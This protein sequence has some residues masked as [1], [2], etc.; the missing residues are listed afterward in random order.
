MKQI[1]VFDTWSEHAELN[2]SEDSYTVLWYDKIHGVEPFE[3]SY[4]SLRQAV[5]RY[6][7]FMNTN[8]ERLN[9]DGSRVC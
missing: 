2:E 7:E 3:K 1:A 4:T 5:M 9:P 8:F 6:N